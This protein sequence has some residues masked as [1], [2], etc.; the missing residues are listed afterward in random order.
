MERKHLDV[1]YEI[2]GPLAPIANGLEILRL[3]ANDAASLHVIEMMQ[4][5]M[6]TLVDVLNTRMPARWQR[7]A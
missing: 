5:Q 6:D 1:A 7:S 2:R 3:T 4:R